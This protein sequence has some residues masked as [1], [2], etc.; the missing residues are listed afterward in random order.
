MS[1]AHIEAGDNLCANNNDSQSLT[2]YFSGLADSLS[3]TCNEK[4]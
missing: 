1:T 4:Y 3:V 2:L